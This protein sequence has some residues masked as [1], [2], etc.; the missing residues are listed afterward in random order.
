MNDGTDAVIKA[1][2]RRGD[3][4]ALERIYDRYG[5]L[6]HRY[7][8]VLIGVRSLAEDV[9]QDLFVRIADKRQVVAEARDLAPYLVGMA[10]NLALK[11]QKKFSTAPLPRPDFIVAAQISSALDASEQQGIADEFLRLP[12]EQREVIGLKV[13]QHMT[14]DQIGAVLAIP[15]NTAASRY[16]YGM[17]KLS[18]QLKGLKDAV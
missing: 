5:E 16:R 9:M 4:A 6:L 13:F 7:L 17:A 1:L 2:L 14:F 11:L 12:V 3:P 15:L 18:D 10:R 8:L